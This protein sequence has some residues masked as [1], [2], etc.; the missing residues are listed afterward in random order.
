MAASISGHMAHAAGC[1]LGDA[2][3][4]A[5]EGGGGGGGGARLG[6]PVGRWMAAGTCRPISNGWQPPPPS[7]LPKAQ[8]RRQGKKG[9]GWSELL[10]SGSG[11]GR[12]RLPLPLRQRGSGATPQPR[13][14]QHLLSTHRGAGS[15]PKRHKRQH[16]P[17][18][19]RRERPLPLVSLEAWWA[20]SWCT[21]MA[22]VEPGAAMPTW[23]VSVLFVASRPCN[24]VGVRRCR[25]GWW[26]GFGGGRQAVG[27]RCG[28]GRAG[29]TGRQAGTPALQPCP[30]A[31]LPSRRSPCRPSG[32]CT[33][34]RAA[35]GGL[36]ADARKVLNGVRAELQPGLLGGQLGRRLAD[37][38]LQRSGGRERGGRGIR[39]SADEVAAG[40]GRPG[41]QAQ[42]MRLWQGRAEGRGCRG[43][44]P[45]TSTHLHWPPTSHPPAPTLTHRRQLHVARGRRLH[46]HHSHFVP[47]RAA[48]LSA[49]GRRE[50]GGRRSLARHA[51]GRR[52]QRRGAALPVNGPPCPLTAR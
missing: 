37:L 25:S 9:P 17:H 27:R 18:C 41:H 7:V 34:W 24:G 42:L 5:W 12:V 1:W 29:Q 46:H 11:S 10:C 47:E 48:A 28:F 43:A 14:P 45:T 33:E 8:R 35:G 16:P 23:S 6:Y 22:A 13:S 36:L 49:L 19:P 26:V 50:G 52:R 32:P 40:Q 15:G 44:A 3:G 21:S 31:S 39:H 30:A 20:R 51:A 2:G 38:A 4:A